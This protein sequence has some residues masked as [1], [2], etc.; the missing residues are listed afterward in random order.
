[1][2]GGQVAALVV[3]LLLLLPGGC[4]LFV[5]TGMLFD[6]HQDA[7]ERSLTPLALGIGL[8]IA[9]LVVFLFWFAF[10]RRQLPADPQP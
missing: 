9:A 3:A 7:I 10:R 8:A 1:M 2:S 4:F 5:G 6:P